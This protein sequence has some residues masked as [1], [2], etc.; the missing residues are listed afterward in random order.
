MS[1]TKTIAG[2]EYT[3][4]YATLGHKASFAR[5]FH[6]NK[7]EV[8]AVGGAA[9]TDI[10][11]TGCIAVRRPEDTAREGL[12]AAD[13]LSAA[14]LLWL[15]ACYEALHV[16]ATQAQRWAG[17]LSGRRETSVAAFEAAT[18]AVAAAEAAFEVTDAAKKR[19]ASVLSSVDADSY[20]VLGTNG[21][22]VAGDQSYFLKVVRHGNVS[23]PAEKVS[24]PPAELTY[25]ITIEYVIDGQTRRD[26]FVTL[27]VA[28]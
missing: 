6:I 12:Q 8:N 4:N 9:P 11:V 24:L 25:S 14:A 19:A 5:P 10:T 13:T 18:E 21:G 2:T 17:D 27:I 22:D 7:V 16:A 15:R 20:T 23:L 28:A 1:S 3:S 26:L